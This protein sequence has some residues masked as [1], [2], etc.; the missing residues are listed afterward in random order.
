MSRQSNL[1]NAFWLIMI[2][3]LGNCQKAVLKIYVNFMSLDSPK[4]QG[5]QQLLNLCEGI[6]NPH[7]SL[8]SS[9]EASL[10]LTSFNH[11][12]EIYSMRSFGSFISINSTQSSLMSNSVEEGLPKLRLIFG[13]HLKVPSM[14]MQSP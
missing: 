3:T 7:R 8:Y 9:T 13:L 2:T 12:L 11:I 1:H 6:S 5:S 10:F 14:C 4:L